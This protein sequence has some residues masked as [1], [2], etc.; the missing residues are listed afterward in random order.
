MSAVIITPIL[1]RNLT[2]QS[3][4]SPRE[5]L[6][7][8]VIAA[9]AVDKCR[10]SLDGT[11]GDY[12]FDGP[13]DKMLFEFKAISA[14]Q[15]KSAAQSLSTYEEV[16]RWLQTNGQSKT[17]KEIKTWSDSIEALRPAHDPEHA[18]EFSEECRRIGLNP[19]KSSLFDLLEADDRAAS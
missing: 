14:E 9:R 16:G 17:L 19:L 3:P 10:A 2:R 15:F 1:P 5:R 6:G 7:G 18:L 8:F 4:H 12:Q 13:L 11:V